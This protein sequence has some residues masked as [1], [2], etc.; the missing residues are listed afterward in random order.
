MAFKR[1]YAHRPF[2]D[3]LQLSRTLG[4]AGL[5]FCQLILKS[6][7]AFIQHFIILCLLCLV[8]GKGIIQ[9][10]IQTQRIAK[11]VILLKKEKDTE[12]DVDN[13]KY[14]F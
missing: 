13:K 6:V 5:K 3:K 9:L 12:L 11:L 8:Q 14:L 7:V 10:G 1:L 2:I 4:V